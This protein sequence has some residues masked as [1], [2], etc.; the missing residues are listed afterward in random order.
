V[1]V[2]LAGLITCTRTLRL[3]KSFAL[4]LK[5][6][7]RHHS[8]LKVMLETTSNIVKVE[9]KSFIIIQR[10]RLQ[11]LFHKCL[12]SRNSAKSASLIKPLSLSVSKIILYAISWLNVYSSFE[13]LITN[14]Q[15]K[16]IQNKE[17]WQLLFAP[18]ETTSF[19]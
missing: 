15:N 11:E 19:W 4:F 13:P 9:V 3:L 5:S 8:V 6:F 17:I 7:R 18:F 16:T 1:Q 10:H 14:V 2:I 12:L